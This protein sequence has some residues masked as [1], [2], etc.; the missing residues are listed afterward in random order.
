MLELL[1]GPKPRLPFLL[2]T[3][4]SVS[5]FEPLAA[6]PLRLVDCASHSVNPRT[7]ARRLGR[8]SVPIGGR[9]YVLHPDS[10]T[11]AQFEAALRGV[12]L[13]AFD[14]Q[15][16]RDLAEAIYRDQPE[17]ILW[18]MPGC[19][20]DDLRRIRNV[21]LG[22][23]LP[24]VVVASLGDEITLED[25]QNAGACDLMTLPLPC[26]RLA[27][28]ISLAM[29]RYDVLESLAD[30]HEEDGNLRAARNLVWK[31]ARVWG[32]RHGMDATE[33]LRFVVS[34]SRARRQSLTRTA[35]EMVAEGLFS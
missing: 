9:A 8:K 21:C 1:T 33:T 34:R 29:L 35:M 26:S 30:E 15:S 16:E 13:V 19:S 25:V 11:R 4:A 20:A 7:A 14:F 18:G 28:V 5:S 32:K 31:A 2:G 27:A 22:S 10:Q 12:G 23:V 3:A 17:I 6:G 24:I